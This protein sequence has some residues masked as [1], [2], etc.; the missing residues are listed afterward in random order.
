MWDNTTTLT[1]RPA[2]AKTL[3][4][5]LRVLHARYRART[6]QDGQAHLLRVILVPVDVD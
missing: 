2:N 4:R 3:Q 1:L 5:E 6:D